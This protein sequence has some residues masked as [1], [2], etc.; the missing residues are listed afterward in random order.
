MMNCFQGL[1]S[2]S[3]L[4]RYTAEQ[5][6]ADSCATAQAEKAKLEAS[7]D[8]AFAMKAAREA[9]AYSRPLFSSA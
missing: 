9:G 8:A 6:A 7:R 4:R 1:I 5:R 2:I 3:T